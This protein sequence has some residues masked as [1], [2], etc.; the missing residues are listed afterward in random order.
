VGECEVY[1]IALDRLLSEDR[2]YVDG[3]GTVARELPLLSSTFVIF[4]L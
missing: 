3:Y 1:R 4:H 2:T